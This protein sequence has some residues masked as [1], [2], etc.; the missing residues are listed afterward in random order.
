MHRRQASA[1]SDQR[2]HRGEMLILSRFKNSSPPCPNRNCPHLY[3]AWRGEHPTKSAS[4]P[5]S[6]PIRSSPVFKKTTSPPR[7]LLTPCSNVGSIIR[8]I[9]P[10]FDISC[11]PIQPPRWSPSPDTWPTRPPRPLSGLSPTRSVKK[12]CS[13][14][15]NKRSAS[16]LPSPAPS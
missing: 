9:P 11:S 13:M 10:S 5:T 1:E 6:P 12:S 3:S 2:N 16:T 4:S 14:N 7:M 8:P 15:P